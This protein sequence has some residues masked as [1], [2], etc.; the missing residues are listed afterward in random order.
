MGIITTRPPAAACES[1]GC[2]AGGRIVCA[3]D[4]QPHPDTFLAVVIVPGG[5]SGSIAHDESV[6]FAR[7]LTQIHAD[8]ATLAYG[9]GGTF[10]LAE[11][12]LL[13]GRAVTTHWSETEAF[14]TDFPGIDL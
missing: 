1:L 9:C 13:R 8:G 10:S 2:H 4:T 3:F 7:W 12:G 14:R 5:P 11:T 6:S